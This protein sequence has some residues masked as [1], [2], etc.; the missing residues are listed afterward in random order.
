M[1]PRLRRMVSGVPGVGVYTPCSGRC[2]PG[3][4]PISSLFRPPI[5]WS[6]RYMQ[7]FLFRGW[8]RI[9]PGGYWFHEPRLISNA[10]VNLGFPRRAGR[11][12]PAGHRRFLSPICWGCNCMG[13]FLIRRWDIGLRWL[14]E[15]SESANSQWGWVFHTA[16]G[17]IDPGDHCLHYRRV[18]SCM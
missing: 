3:G 16:R 12:R 2:C 14:H 4:K 9:L 13:Q 5:R 6:C 17:G 1:R 15:P 10:P 8:D 7:D 18:K 11:H